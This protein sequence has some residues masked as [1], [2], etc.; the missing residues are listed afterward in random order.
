MAEHEAVSIGID[1]GDPPPVPVWVACRHTPAASLDESTED[2]V[3][4][5]AAEVEHEEV[6]IGLTGRS[7][8][9]RVPDQ[10]KVPGGPWPPEHQQGMTTLGVGAASMQHLKAQA[11]DPEPLGL[12]KVA[13]GPGDAQVVRSGRLDT[14]I[15][16]CRARMRPADPSASAAAGA[17][18]AVGQGPAT[19]SLSTRS[20]R[21]FGGLG[22]PSCLQMAI[23]TPGPSSL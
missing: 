20:Q 7:L 9:G 3:I 18:V 2:L 22:T 1:D 17:K 11:V 14:A 15:I 5:R 19:Y 23:A 13:R 6:F 10:F 4:E 12:L 8:P 16:A 21:G